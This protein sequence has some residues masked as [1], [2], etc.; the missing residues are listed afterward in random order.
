MHK[1]GEIIDCSGGGF[2]DGGEA[3][4]HDTMLL[5][6]LLLLLL[7]HGINI[8]HRIVSIRID[9]LAE[10]RDLLVA[11]HRQRMH[12]HHE[13]HSILKFGNK[14]RVRPQPAHFP[15]GGFSPFP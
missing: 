5:L 14:I 3:F 4:G 12:L 11:C 9:I 6:L 7:L 15:A 1:V 2:V 13:L 8:L 10:Q